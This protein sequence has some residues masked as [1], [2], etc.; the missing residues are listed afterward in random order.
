MRLGCI[1]LFILSVTG[2]REGSGRKDIFDFYHSRWLGEIE[3]FPF[4]Q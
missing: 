4:V 3:D 2:N 1:I